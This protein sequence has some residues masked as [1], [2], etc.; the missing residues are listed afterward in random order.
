MKRSQIMQAV[1]QF[2][3]EHSEPAAGAD[4]YFA[5]RQV[6]ERSPVQMIPGQFCDPVDQFGD[7]GSEAG[8]DIIEG[9]PGNVLDNIVQKGRGQQHG[10]CEVHLPDQDFG[11][12]AGMADVRRPGFSLLARVQL[13]G[14]IEGFEK[15]SVIGV[16]GI[17]A[18]GHAGPELGEI[19]KVHVCRSYR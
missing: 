5:V 1:G 14:K 7:P 18:F 12:G 3:D 16:C 10:I 13:R 6:F 19:E 15:K 8:F 2:Y 11:D 9:Y 17:E 4:E